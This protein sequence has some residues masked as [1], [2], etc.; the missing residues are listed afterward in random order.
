MWKIHTSTIVLL[1]ALAIPSLGQGRMSTTEYREFLASI[2]S[3]VTRWQ[4]ELDEFQVENLKIDFSNGKTIDDSRTVAV[5]NL[6]LIRET[7][8]TQR[9][10]EKLSDDV[11]LEGALKDVETMM[12]SM[13]NM[14]MDQKDGSRWAVQFVVLPREIRP[15]RRRL[16]EHIVAFADQLQTKAD[17]CSH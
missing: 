6:A 7:T 13:A 4:T 17:K 12:M 1:T 2:D 14:L 11:V 15:M 10:H 5:Q 9:G 8:Q 3:S 16:R